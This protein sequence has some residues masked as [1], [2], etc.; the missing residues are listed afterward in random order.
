[1]VTAQRGLQHKLFCVSTFWPM[2]NA[3]ELTWSWRLSGISAVKSYGKWTTVQR[4]VLPWSSG[5][6]PTVCRSRDTKNY[7]VKNTSALSLITNEKKQKMCVF[8]SPAVSNTRPQHPNGGCHIARATASYSSHTHY[9]QLE[10]DLEHSVPN[11]VHCGMS[12]IKEHSGAT[13]LPCTKA[14]LLNGWKS[15]PQQIT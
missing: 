5:P 14:S 2:F 8:I 7:K 3:A 12:H 10:V 15:Y 6:S 13:L 1:M 9:I 11:C 4:C